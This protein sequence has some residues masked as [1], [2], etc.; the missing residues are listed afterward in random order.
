MDNKSKTE[1]SANMRAIRSSDTKPEIT[2]RRLLFAD[3]F[4]FRLHVKTLPGK[5]DIVLPKWKTVDIVNR[6]F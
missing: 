5:P 3:G 4:R 6:C 2:V 1:R